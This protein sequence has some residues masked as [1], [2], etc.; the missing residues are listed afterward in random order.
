MYC[1]LESGAR[2]LEIF[3]QSQLI[4]LC[5][6][7]NLNYIKQDFQ[8]G[9]FQTCIG[10]VKNYGRNTFMNGRLH[11]K[12]YIISQFENDLLFS[13][14][15][16]IFHNRRLIINVVIIKNGLYPIWTKNEMSRISH[17]I[18]KGLNSAFHLVNKLE[19]R[20]NICIQ[21][22]CN[23]SNVRLNSFEEMTLLYMSQLLIL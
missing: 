1:N 5:S 21:K 12:H 2:H 19:I 9:L 16:P 13:K 3:K 14:S 22:G 20:F 7:L 4:S 10:H 17:M 6:F 8:Q 18:C 23:C 11:M 15:P